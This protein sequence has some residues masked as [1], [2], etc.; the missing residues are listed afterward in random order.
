MKARF[1][2]CKT[3]APLGVLDAPTD[4]KAAPSM[5]PGTVTLK[6]RANRFAKAYRVQ[7]ATDITFPEATSKTQIAS[8]ANASVKDLA[9]A[10]RY[11]F[12]V[13]CIGAAG[14]SQWTNPT[15]VVTQ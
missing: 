14:P 1:D 6:W 10:T 8:R 12:R 11:W 9:S 2:Q 7:F 4:L 3:S 5:N 13:A 15:A